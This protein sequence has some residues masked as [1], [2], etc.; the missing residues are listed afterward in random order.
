MRGRTATLLI[1]DDVEINPK[2]KNM[3]TLFEAVVC[4]KDKNGYLE[5]IL[6]GPITLLARDKDAAALQVVVNNATIFT[7]L[8]MSEVSIQVRPFK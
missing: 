2:E 5:S 3:N 1:I 4:K 7:G 6:L 8:D